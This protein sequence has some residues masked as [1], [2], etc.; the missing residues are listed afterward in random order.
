LGDFGVKIGR[1]DL[2][3]FLARVFDP[4]SY[5]AIPN[6]FN[7]YENPLQA[8][9]NET[10][11]LG[12][13]PSQVELKTSIGKHKIQLFSASDFSTLNLIFCR[14]DYY[15]PQ[16]LKTVVDIGSNIGLSTFYWLTRNPDC[17]VYCYEPSPI[18]YER[19]TKNLQAF[20]DRFQSHQA[21]VSDF[22][23]T[24]QF[25]IEKSGV[26]STLDFVKEASEREFIDN[27]DCQVLHINDILE[28]V[29]A[30]RGR[31]D[32]L[33]ID[34]EGHE[35]RTIQ[36]IDPSFWPHIYCVNTD[37]TGAA[38]YIPKDFQFDHLSSAERF[39]R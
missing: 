21:A 30:Q 17:F 28:A 7:T 11:S 2:G 3:T 14:K 22:R 35:L 36:A 13:Y 34:S 38:E 37:C 20:T 4:D 24:A 9:I 33:K 19:L 26:Y 10:F 25:G 32:V 31:V 8:I 18:S 23:G 29:L 16:Y 12:S 27:I 39:Y 15:V 1:R 5:Q 6:F